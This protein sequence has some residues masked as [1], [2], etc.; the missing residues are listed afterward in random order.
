VICQSCGANSADINICEYCGSRIK[1]LDTSDILLEEE[2]KK[3]Q[4]LELSGDLSYVYNDKENLDQV[5]DRLIEKV[6]AFLESKELKKAEFFSQLAIKANS[7]DERSLFASAL[8][9]VEFAAK[10]TGS[11]QMANIKQKYLAESKKILD[12][13]DFDS[14]KEDV[15]ELQKRISYLEGKKASDFTIQGDSEY[16]ALKDFKDNASSAAS[17]AAEGTGKF[18]TG[19]LTVIGWIIGIIIIIGIFLPV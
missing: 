11:I 13:T 14:M 15:E 1:V 8:V 16:D 5:L 4:I 12:K 19:C 18:V 6:N 7:N 10:T 17:S 9:K 2:S 3:A